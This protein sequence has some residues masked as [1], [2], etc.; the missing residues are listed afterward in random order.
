[1]TLLSRMAG[2][3]A[4]LP[5][6]DTRRVTVER[7]LATPMPDGTVLLADRWYPATLRVGTAP[8]VLLRS[9]YGR[10]QL[11]IVGR[12]DQHGRH[13]VVPF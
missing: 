4:H 9:P 3:L 1:M 7:D 10:R 13:A 5:P 11:G 6:A 12:L 8:T 2:A